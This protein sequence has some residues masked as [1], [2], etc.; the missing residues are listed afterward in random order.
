MPVFPCAN[1]RSL[2][3]KGTATYSDDGAEQT[4]FEHTSLIRRTVKSVYL[5]MSNM[6]QDGTI[7]VYYKIDGATYRECETVAFTAAGLD[8]VVIKMGVGV[9]DAFKVTY[10]ETVDEAA[11][12]S[13]PY[14]CVYEA[15]ER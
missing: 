7:K 3:S 12:R 10:T 15:G 5:D 11:A 9:T 1:I 6:T 14:L 8:G 2:E 13:I 4:I